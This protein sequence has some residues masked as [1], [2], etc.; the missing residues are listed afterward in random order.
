MSVSLS[1]SLGVPGL[2][3][4]GAPGGVSPAPQLSPHP[5]LCPGP[6]QGCRGAAEAWGRAL[7]LWGGCCFVSAGGSCWARGVPG[8]DAGVGWMGG[9]LWAWLIGGWERGAEVWGGA[10]PFGGG[11]GPLEGAALSALSMGRGAPV[12]PHPI[13]GRVWG[14]MVGDR[15]CG[16]AQ[17]LCPFSLGF[18]AWW[19]QQ[20]AGRGGL[21]THGGCSSG[22]VS[23][24]PYALDGRISPQSNV[25]FDRSLRQR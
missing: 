17:G 12:L 7:H 14:A 13:Q 23:R 8:G 16:P 2:G 3:G 20:P 10:Q 25:D 11:L 6:V 21:R 24:Q 18:C 1:P 15:T 19:G 9:Q 5:S 4:V 22:L